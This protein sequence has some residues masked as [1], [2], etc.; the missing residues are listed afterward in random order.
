MID[1]VI[2]DPH[3]L[4]R[5]ALAR[6]MHQDPELRVAAEAADGRAA[7]AAIRAYEPAVAV[8]AREL[9]DLDGDRLLV[10]VLRARPS[11]RV[12]MLDADPGPGTW[13]LLGNGAA[14]ILSRRVSGEVIRRSVHSVARGGT[15]LCDEVQAAIATEVRARRPE[16]S[17]LSP[18]E[19]QVLELVAEGLSTP[20][21][22]QR[23]QLGATT[24]KTHLGHLYDKLGARD[25]ARLVR[26][27]M[28][29]NLLD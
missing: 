15:A 11:T 2:A 4:F 27:A 1:V 22:A 7:L 23:L 20:A 19:Q 18:R 9:G 25:R 29:R 13:E 5:D 16:S 21:I 28:R 10:A 14:G 3:P 6:V 8:L 12:L 24:V 17:L 26:E